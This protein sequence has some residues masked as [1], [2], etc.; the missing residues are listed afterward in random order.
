MSKLRYP[1]EAPLLSCAGWPQLLYPSPLVN[2]ALHRSPLPQHQSHPIDPGDLY[3]LLQIQI[4]PCLNAQ[5]AHPSA[6][7]IPNL[8]LGS[9]PGSPS[10]SIL[11]QVHLYEAHLTRFPFKKAIHACLHA[12][13]RFCSFSMVL[14]WVQQAGDKLE[15]WHS[16]ACNN[17][18]NWWV[19]IPR[20][21]TPY[22]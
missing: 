5:G 7:E 4:D 22:F 9:L 16:L 18:W 11:E 14:H 3:N 10:I 20:E 19:M 17:G 15:D 12:N 13:I 6:T 8:H 21:R 2:S 1:L